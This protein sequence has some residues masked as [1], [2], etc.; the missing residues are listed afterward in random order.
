[1]RIEPFTSMGFEK[2]THGLKKIIEKGY[3][4]DQLV[5][6]K[7][8]TTISKPLLAGNTIVLL[9]KMDITMRRRPREK[10]KELYFY[11][12]KNGKIISEEFFM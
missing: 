10:M 11:K 8:S 12:V 6:S 4:F 1:M 9:L 3:K 2:E 7:H 5:K